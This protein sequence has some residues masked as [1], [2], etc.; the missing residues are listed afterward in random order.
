MKIK[1][2]N[3]RVA[4]TSGQRTLTDLKMPGGLTLAIVKNTK[5]IIAAENDYLE[6]HKA[7][8][9]ARC[10]KGQDGVP[11]A[12]D[13]DGINNYSFETPAVEQEVVKAITELGETEV[14]LP[15]LI[16]VGSV[17]LTQMEL[18]PAQMAAIL[19]IVPIKE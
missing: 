3:L 19:L 18:T 11:V 6:A 9:E 14:E 13:K 17:H 7:I 15:N 5:E 4:Y 8:I 16:S 10:V 2:K 1:N 12:I